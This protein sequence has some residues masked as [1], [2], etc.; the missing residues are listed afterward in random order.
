MHLFRAVCIL[1][2]LVTF[3]YDILTPVIGG[4]MSE[5]WTEITAA[6][7]GD[8]TFIGQNSAG[9][10]VQM[11]ILDNK[12]GVGPMQ[13]LLVALAGCTGTDIVS[14]LL[15]KRL[16]LTD[17]Q[18]MVRGLRSDDYPKIWTRIEVTY[19]LWGDNLLDKDVE[20]AIRLSEEKY[21]SVSAMLEKSAKIS[22]T[23]KILKP[24]E[25]TG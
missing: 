1:S 2:K 16:N 25:K 23:Y 11:G 22:S 7:K 13:L 4:T 14:I 18:L 6:W 15:K 9:G 12:P 21:C 24:G 19:Y 8:Q 3:F 10:S 5:D 20:Q 17:F